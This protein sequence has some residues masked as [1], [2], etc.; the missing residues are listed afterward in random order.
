M[1]EVV[2][3]DSIQSLCA[4]IFLLRIKRYPAKRK[5]ALAEFK[6][7]LMLGRYETGIKRYVRTIIH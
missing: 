2:K 3:A 5:R 1:A 7:A 4:I 6:A